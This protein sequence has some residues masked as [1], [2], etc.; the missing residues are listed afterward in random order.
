M[1]YKK[2]LPTGE[3]LP[4]T[5]EL[6]PLSKAI[7][8][9]KSSSFSSGATMTSICVFT[10]AL[11]CVKKRIEIPTLS[12]STKDGRPLSFYFLFDLATP[13]DDS[14]KDNLLLLLPSIDFKMSDTSSPPKGNAFHYLFSLCPNPEDVIP[15]I[16]TRTDLPLFELLTSTITEPLFGEPHTPL[17]TAIYD[18]NSEALLRTFFTAFSKHYRKDLSDTLHFKLPN[19]TTVFDSLITIKPILAPILEPFLSPSS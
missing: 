18:Y 2:I 15:L 8:S 3:T 10:S 16:A 14:A 12:I 11:L 9:F 13:L 5:P 19:G 7:E 1:I 4:M 6:Q 17:H